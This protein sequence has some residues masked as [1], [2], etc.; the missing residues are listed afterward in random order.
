MPIPLK[1]W[2][3][4]IAPL[5][6]HI[7]ALAQS[8]KT[9]AIQLNKAVSYLAFQPPWISIAEEQLLG[10]LLTLEESIHQLRQAKDSFKNKSI[11]E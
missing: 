7:E 5:L 2:D 3:T 4:D 8:I 9:R 11:G 1:E 6:H 10:A